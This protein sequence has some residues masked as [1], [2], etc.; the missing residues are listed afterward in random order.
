MKILHISFADSGGAGLCC[1]RIHQSLLN[2]G[3][4][5]KVVCFYKKSNVPEVY[6][7]GNRTTLF[8]ER[9]FSKF[10]D[11][12]GIRLTKRS[13]LQELYREKNAPYSLIT[14]F[15]DLSKCEWVEWA[16]I[17]H[18][19]WVNWYVDYP[20]FFQ[21]VK[22]SIVMTLHDENL[23]CGAAHF[24]RDILP[25]NEMERELQ[26]L[27]LKAIGP[28]SNVTIVFLSE[29]LHR[30]FK[31]HPIVNGKRLVVINNSVDGGRYHIYNKFEMRKKYQISDDCI[32]FA[33]MA[34]DIFTR[35]KGLDVLVSVLDE[36]D[37]D[38]RIRILAIGDNPS[39]KDAPAIVVSV[40]QIDGADEVS[41]L[42]SCCDFFAM[43]SYQEAFAQSPLE[44]MACGLPV[45]A[46]PCSG[47]SELVN[48][49]NGVICKDFTKE[50]LYDGIR[51]LLSRDYN[52]Q[53][54]R[55]DVLARFS[56]Q[57]IAEKYYKLYEEIV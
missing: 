54:I 45:V 2:L 44:A 1:L 34:N 52:H 25:D 6:R 19:H 4:E 23:F 29:Y 3:V 35:L 38:N 55:D 33:F 5:S 37:K 49:K 12:I 14:S 57:V 15:F 22:K 41:R 10:L 26:Q 42:L 43:P 27:K 47:V 9:A 46:F 50:A 11:L 7:Y 16:D 48:E 36:I 31:D 56:S 20:S 51:L 21:K 8:L 39:N 40:G 30:Q 28:R 24:T 18:L 17:I 32:L 53:E 13:R